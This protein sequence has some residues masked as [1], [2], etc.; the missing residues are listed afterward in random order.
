MDSLE[1]YC[2]AVHGRGRYTAPEVWHKAVNRVKSRVEAYLLVS[3]RMITRLE[4][5]VTKDEGPQA[6]AI[7]G[8]Q[9][10]REAALRPLG[11]VDWAKRPPALT[12]TVPW[13]ELKQLL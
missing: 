3:G 7:M 9:A 11:T 6:A 12:P 13:E 5:W 4:T 2:N 10:K 8:E 1:A